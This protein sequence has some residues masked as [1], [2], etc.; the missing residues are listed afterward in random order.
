MCF[1]FLSII[2]NYLSS[3]LVQIKDFKG[4]VQTDWVLTR[5][6]VLREKE[7]RG[8]KE[9]TQLRSLNSKVFTAFRRWSRSASSGDKKRSSSQNW[10]YFLNIIVIYYS[11]WIL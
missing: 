6:K 1:T 10:E 9:I 4:V 11:E 7:A 8:L 2:S 5:R 3:S